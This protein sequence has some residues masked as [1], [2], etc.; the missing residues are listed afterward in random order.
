MIRRV[1][2]PL[3]AHPLAQAHSEA[4]PA[5]VRNWWYDPTSGRFTQEDPIGFA[6]GTNFTAR[7][8]PTYA[9]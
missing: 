5:A 2:A 6:G 3:S 1:R 4:E 9:A 7:A 8:V